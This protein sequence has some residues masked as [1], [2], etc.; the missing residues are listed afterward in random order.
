MPV[1]E[2]TDNSVQRIAAIGTWDGVHRGHRH[3]L[4]FLSDEAQK[5][6]LRPSV[7]T[8]RSHPLATVRP[9][10][11]PRLICSVEERVNRLEQAGIE[12][13]I[14]MD[15]DDRLRSLT[16]REFMHLLKDEYGVTALVLGFN[17]SFGS[18]RLQD[19]EAYKAIGDEIGMTVIQAPEWRADDDAVSSSAVRH[20]IAQGDVERAGS[21]LSVPVTLSGEVV[22]GQQLGR[23]I[24]F[25]TANIKTAPELAIPASGVYVAEAI[26]AD[27]VTHRA[28]VNIGKRPTVDKSAEPVTTVEAHLLDFDGDLYGSVL[29]LKFIK[30]LRDEQ[31][32]PSL[33][34]LT[35]QLKA[36]AQA[37]RSIQ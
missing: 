22:K 9:E 3:L 24:G 37:A 6:G 33:D 32:F 26:T 29:T 7:V 20:L 28:I 12:D 35:A 34:A 8:F 5:L 30:R 15:F 23:T 27:G 17:N 10:R 14:L 18:D 16:A 4:S 13:V 11:V 36:D 31:R 19:I 25:P 1:V 21:W 2:Q